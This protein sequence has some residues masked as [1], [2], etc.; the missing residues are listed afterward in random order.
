MSHLKCMNGFAL[1]KKI[2]NKN[3][4][5]SFKQL[6]FLADSIR[7][8]CLTLYGRSLRRNRMF[9]V[10]KK[11]RLLSRSRVA[12]VSTAVHFLSALGSFLSRGTSCFPLIKIAL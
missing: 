7:D 6:I 9:I 10:W 5:K 3:K 2:K 11:S 12:D 4:K 1:L 8:A